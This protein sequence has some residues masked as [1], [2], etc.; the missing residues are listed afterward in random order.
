MR[1]DRLPS[2]QTVGSP[3]TSDLG[4]QREVSVL[5]M[6][7]SRDTPFVSLTFHHRRCIAKQH[8][9]RTGVRL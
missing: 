1:S 3:D 4:V 7:P 6:Q 5:H 2:S 8:L 9:E